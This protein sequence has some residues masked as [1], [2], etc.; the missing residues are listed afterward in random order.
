MLNKPAHDAWTAG[1]E[2]TNRNEN[3]TREE[4]TGKGKRGL[5]H[6]TTIEGDGEDVKKRKRKCL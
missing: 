4:N 6:K 1:R 2:D 3:K 5:N